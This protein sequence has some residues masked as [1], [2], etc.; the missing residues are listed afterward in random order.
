M[1]LL[2][3]GSRCSGVNGGEGKPIAGILD[4]ALTYMAISASVSGCPEGVGCLFS[5]LIGTGPGFITVGAPAFGR[6][7]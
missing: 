1:I 7:C 2:V 4:R 6:L 5:K 3:L